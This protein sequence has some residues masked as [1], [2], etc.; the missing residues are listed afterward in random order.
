M[1][2]YLDTIKFAENN[3]E[4]V[5]GIVCQDGNIIKSPSLIQLTP[6]VAVQKGKIF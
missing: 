4:N 1:H 2:F 6:G 3:P 5:V